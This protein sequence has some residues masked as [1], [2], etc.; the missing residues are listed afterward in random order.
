MSDTTHPPE[1]TPPIGTRIDIAHAFAH[2]PPPLDMVLRGLRPGAVGALIAP[3]GMSKSYLALQICAEVASGGAYADLGLVPEEAKPARAIYFGA[4]DDA[5]VLHQRLYALGTHLTPETQ[6]L[7]ADN[8]SCLLDVVTTIG[9]SRPLMS[10]A[11]EI[12]AELREQ[13]TA[14]ALGARLVFLDPL[15]QLHDGDEND[16]RD[17]TIIL[18]ALAQIAHES[19]AAI[20][21]VHHSRKGA[22][23]DRDTSDAS[24]ARGSVAL[25][26]NVRYVLALSRLSDARIKEYGV[27]ENDASW[28]VTLDHAKVSHIAIPPTM[29]LHRRADGTLYHDEITEN[30][31][32]IDRAKPRRGKIVSIAPA[33]EP[34]KK[35]EPIHADDLPTFAEYID[36]L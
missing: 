22:A 7:V 25:T 19:G 31:R 5:E 11:R 17:V 6:A 26:D 30:A 4:E 23:L 33:P 18:R 16:S 10:A 21:Y 3:G 14:Y 24:A 35:K 9:V 29:L 34:T 1:R 28:Y 36:G 8:K 13:I 32:E 27:A 12:D 20:I 2:A 15:R